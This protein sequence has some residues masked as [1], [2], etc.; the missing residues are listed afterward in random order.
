M[1]KWN[2]IKMAAALIACAMLAASVAGCHSSGTSESGSA[3]PPP[4]TGYNPAGNKAE[5]IGPL[6]E[7]MEDSAVNG[8]DPAMLSVGQLLELTPKNMLGCDG[9]DPEKFFTPFYKTQIQYNEGFFL[10]ENEAGGIDNISL[11]FPAKKILEVRSNDLAT[12]YVEGRDYVLNADGT[13]S[14]PTNSAIRPVKRNAFFTTGGQWKWAETDGTVINT[15]D[16]MYR[17][18][19]VCTY[20]R[21]D[22]YEGT[23]ANACGEKLTAFSDKTAA[24]ER[25]EILILGDS[26]T[27]GAGRKNFPCWVDMVKDG[28]EYYSDSKVDLY[29]TAVPGIHSAEYVGLIEGDAERVDKNIRED[30]V[31]KFAVAEEHKAA[32]DLAIIGVGA[33]DAGGWCGPTG[34][35]VANYSVN[36]KKM[37]RYIRDVNPDCSILLVSCMQTNPRIIDAA[38]G[39]RLAA[40]DLSTYED[41][42]AEIVNAETNI[43]L[44]NVYSVEQ[45]LLERK[46][47]EDMLGDNIN[48][49]S[50][51]M[52]RVYTQVVLTALFDL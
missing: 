23:K 36:V 33:N 14:I 35:P 52:A 18:Q 24:G 5:N 49:P 12:L 51:Y 37:I 17:G 26:I 8:N 45:S 29:N 46:S 7:D 43:G 15:T 6:P 42:L 25:V 16:A 22:E 11:A 47:I 20:I 27:A 9:Y 4:A 50:D 1:K 40:A 41:A 13:L 10:L 48:H 34:T 28:V 39:D 2:G 3:A 38:S 30:A 32:A 31:K 21:T 19:Y 44:A